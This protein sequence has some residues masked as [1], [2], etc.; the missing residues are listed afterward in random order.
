MTDPDE[1]PEGWWEHAGAI[2]GIAA[3]KWFGGDTLPYSDRKHAALDG[4]VEEVME[5]GW[6]G[7]GETFGRLF[8][9]ANNGM[10]HEQRE[11]QKHL[12]WWA[13]WRDGD[14]ITDALAESVT[15]RVAIW[16]V[17]WALTPAEREAVWALAEVQ[18][19]G[20]SNEDAAALLGINPGAYYMRIKNARRKAR[21]WWVAP[22]DTAPRR[23]AAFSR[24][25]KGRNVRTKLSDWRAHRQRFRTVTDGR[26]ELAQ[27]VMS[28]EAH[29]A[30]ITTLSALSGGRIPETVIRRWNRDGELPQ[31]GLV[32]RRVAYSVDE[33]VQVAIR[34]G[35]LGHDP[36]KQAALW[37]SDATGARPPSAQPTPCTRNGQSS[38]WRSPPTPCH[39]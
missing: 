31:R 27:A 23:N 4:I 2:A 25:G 13:H 14:G 17:S 30:D 33:F 6:P 5:A 38:S 16:Q 39:P 9:A 7:P 32:Y 15:D 22:G 8:L 1:L 19:W 36:R 37:P 34:H 10:R 18:R 35:R 3:R 12:Q 28:G 11:A 26:Y 24:G 21:E 20:G 29:L